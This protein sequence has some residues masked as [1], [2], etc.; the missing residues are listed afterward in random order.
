MESVRPSPGLQQIKL[1]GGSPSDTPQYA[2]LPGVRKVA[3]AT[4]AVARLVALK[5]HRRRTALVKVRV[6]LMTAV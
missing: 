4:D 5:A 6:G 2:A 3:V 1:S